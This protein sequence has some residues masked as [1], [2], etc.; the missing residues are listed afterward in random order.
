MPMQIRLT[1]SRNA[2]RPHTLTCYRND[3]TSTGQASSGFFAL[4]D[5]THFAVETT[6]N[7]T[8]AFFGLLAKGW[9]IASFEAREPGSL[10][11]RRLPLE[12]AWAEMLVG[13]YDIERAIGPQPD[14]ERLESFQNACQDKGLIEPDITLDQLAQIRVVRDELFAVWQSLPPGESIELEFPEDADQVRVS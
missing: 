4:H 11:S 7:L 3:G 10:K 12:A 5:L 2:D 9:D 13:T 6:L 14:E 8:D 1:K